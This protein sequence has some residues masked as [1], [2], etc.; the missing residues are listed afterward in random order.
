[1]PHTFASESV[2]VGKIAISLTLGLVSDCP[3]TVISLYLI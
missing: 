3:V 2:I 1:M